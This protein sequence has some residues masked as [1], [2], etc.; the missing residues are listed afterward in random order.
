MCGANP[1]FL[2]FDSL[3]SRGLGL[4]LQR[5]DSSLRLGVEGSSLEIKFDQQ[6]FD[7]RLRSA[8]ANLSQKGPRRVQIKAL[9]LGCRCN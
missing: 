5:R 6:H 7:L 8:S 3:W 2:G 1:W 4:K 9:T